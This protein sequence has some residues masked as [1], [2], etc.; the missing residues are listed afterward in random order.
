[1]ATGTVNGSHVRTA[2]APDGKADSV[3]SGLI[4]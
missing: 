3:L 2:L 1:M 4:R